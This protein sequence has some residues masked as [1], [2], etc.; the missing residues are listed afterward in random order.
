ML[1]SL[2]GNGFI[3]GSASQMVICNKVQNDLFQGMSWVEYFMRS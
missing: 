1:V 3:G 2:V